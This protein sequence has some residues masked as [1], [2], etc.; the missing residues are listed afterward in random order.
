MK[1]IIKFL[2]SITR[3]F[4]EGR[5]NFFFYTF[6]GFTLSI[7][8]GLS[9]T[10]I[11]G[12]LEPFFS[13]GQEYSPRVTVYGGLAFI[14]GLLTF[15]FLVFISVSVWRYFKA[16]RGFKGWGLLLLGVLHVPI[17]LLTILIDATQFFDALVMTLSY[18]Q[19]I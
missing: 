15:I 10:R 9:A 14:F 16:H 8:L 4:Y 7:L 19:I 12:R 17:S 1:K 2:K 5:S 11:Y 18:F 6:V 13:Y 3:H